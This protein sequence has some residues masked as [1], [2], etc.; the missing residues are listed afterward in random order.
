MK[1][2]R[3]FYL[4]LTFQFYSSGL[5]SILDLIDLSKEGQASLFGEAEWD[6]IKSRLMK[7][8]TA[9]RYVLPHKITDAWRIIAAVSM[10]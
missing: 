9:T 1:I 6:N 8:Y 2:N 4:T 3:A 7:K 10:Q 5:S